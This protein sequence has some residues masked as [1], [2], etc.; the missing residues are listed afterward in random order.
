MKITEKI[1][2]PISQ[3]LKIFEKQFYN[4][5]SSKVKLL[6]LIL[7]YIL[8]RKGKQIRPILVLLFAKMFSKGTMSE[9]SYRA[10]NL[11]ELIHT[12]SLIHDDIVDDSNVRRNFLTIN[13]LWKN[14]ISVLVGDFFLSKALLLSTE[15]KD[16]DLLN[17]V[18]KAVKEISEGELFQIQK[19]RNFNLSEEDYNILISKKTASLFSC[20]CKLGS[21]ASGKNNLNDIETFGNYLGIIFQIKDDLF[22]YTTKKIGKPTSDLNSQKITLPLIFSIKNSTYRDK[23]LI[24]VILKK[25]KYTMDNKKMVNEFIIKY[26]GFEYAHNKMLDYKNKALKILKKFPDNDSK[27]SIEILLDYIIERKY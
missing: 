13:A 16:Y 21:I 10:A 22:D 18:S 12:A 25:K 26:K 7:I 15:N 5:V 2:K 19:S 4:S 14:K 27:E 17:E 20:C 1:K 9:K 3:E 11:V 23:K 24:K 8:N 6:D